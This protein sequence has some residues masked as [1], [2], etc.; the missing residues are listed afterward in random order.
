MAVEQARLTE[1]VN[2]INKEHQLAYQA[3][4]DVLDHAIRCGEWLIEARRLV[5]EGSWIKWI[6]SN[7]TIHGSAA[8]RYVRIATYREQLL[9][10]EKRPLSIN[11][12]VNY[13]HDIDVPVLPRGRAG[14]RPTFDVDEAKRLRESGMT[15]HQIGEL[16]GV[17]DVAVGLQL[18]P[19]GPAQKERRLQGARERRIAKQAAIE[20]QIADKIA[21][22]GGNLAETYDLLRR[23]IDALSR[24]LIEADDDELFGALSIALTNMQ[25][26]EEVITRVFK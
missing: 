21:E 19:L 2:A 11:A 12:A 1:L 17:S 5:P 26:A 20:K 15:L 10:A 6:N 16:L 13:L 3:S 7:L 4:L 14:K 22:I 8:A 9:S 24:A 18:K 25:R 23:C